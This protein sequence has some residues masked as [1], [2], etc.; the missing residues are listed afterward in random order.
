MDGGGDGGRALVPQPVDEGA[1]ASDAKP[2]P[3]QGSPMT[4]ATWAV[5]P[6]GSRL[7]VA[8]T[9]PTGVWSVRR[10]TIQLSQISSG[11]PEPAA[12]RS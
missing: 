7:T 11:S 12:S 8:C 4:Q 1:A 9:V 10:R 2:C 6:P 5:Q 3:C